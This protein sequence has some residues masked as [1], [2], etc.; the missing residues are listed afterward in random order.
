MDFQPSPTFCIFGT[1]F[2][3]KNKNFP[4]A[5]NLGGGKVAPALPRDHNAHGCNNFTP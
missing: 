4:Q 2:S 5:K 3:D 1:K